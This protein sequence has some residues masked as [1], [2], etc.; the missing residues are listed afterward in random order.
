MLSQIDQTFTTTASIFPR[1]LEEQKV[2]WR[3]KLREDL[4]YEERD[5]RFLRHSASFLEMALY[6]KEI[7]RNETWKVI[8]EDYSGSLDSLF[9]WMHRIAM[10]DGLLEGAGIS[11]DV[12]Q[13]SPDC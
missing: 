10:F 8:F 7:V 11:K 9:F 4:E 12:N 6:E 13:K 2:I 1:N 5:I 3:K